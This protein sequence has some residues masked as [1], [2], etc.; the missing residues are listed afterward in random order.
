MRIETDKTK[1]I[2]AGYLDFLKQFI[3]A[4]KLCFGRIGITEIPL[5]K[6]SRY[7][8]NRSYFLKLLIQD[9]IIKKLKSNKY[10]EEDKHYLTVNSNLSYK[11]LEKY[12]KDLTIPGAYGFDIK[13]RNNGLAWI[14]RQGY[15]EPAKL[16]Q[17]ESMFFKYLFKNKNKKILRERMS[18]DTG[19]NNSQISSCAGKVRL[20]MQNKLKY[21]KKETEKILPP[22]MKKYIILHTKY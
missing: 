20:K 4:R 2:K 15:D 13:I 18:E 8:K 7:K 6:I 14:T 17:N 5:N 22:R 9:G 19:L 10:S 12:K 21:T 1:M 3:E 11:E 16:S